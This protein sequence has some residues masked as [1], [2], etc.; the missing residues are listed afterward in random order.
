MGHKSPVNAFSTGQISPP[1]GRSTEIQGARS[2]F[3]AH[4]L[5]FYR[6]IPRPVLASSSIE[7]IDPYGRPEVRRSMDAFYGR[8][9]G[10]NQ[11]RLFLFG[12]NPGRFGAGVTGIPFTDGYHLASSCGIANDLPQRQELSASFI[13]RV[14]QEWGGADAFFRQVYIT[15][16]C[17]LGLLQNG[18]NFNYYDDRT[19]MAELE[20]F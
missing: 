4:V 18:V 16:V 19:L 17:P 5:S 8:F 15:A 12:I 13:H 20:P 9:Y 11:Q 3:G 6:T 7:W 10:D 14:V 2:S 1:D